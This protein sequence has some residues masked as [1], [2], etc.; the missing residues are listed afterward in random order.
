M[1]NRPTTFALG[2]VYNDEK[3]AL[4]LNTVDLPMLVRPFTMFVGHLHVSP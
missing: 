1:G 3:A 4:Q 2:K